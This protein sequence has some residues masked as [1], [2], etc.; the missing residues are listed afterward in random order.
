MSPGRTRASACRCGA[1]TRVTDS[2]LLHGGVRRRRVE[3]L[4][5]RDRF[6]TYEGRAADLFQFFL[7]SPTIRHQ[8][9][10]AGIHAVV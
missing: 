8:F 3:C 2:R 5:C 10:E 9:T 1:P 7:R 6:T 4:I